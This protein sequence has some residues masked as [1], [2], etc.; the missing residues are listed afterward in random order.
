VG[1]LENSIR[2][3]RLPRSSDHVDDHLIYQRKFLE[4]T[5]SARSAKEGRD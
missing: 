3:S 5:R 1:D 2:K 4:V